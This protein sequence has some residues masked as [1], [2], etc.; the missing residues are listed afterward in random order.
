VTALFGFT[1]ADGFGAFQRASASA[2]GD[3]CAAGLLI[4]LGNGTCD[5]HPTKRGRDL[6]SQAVLEALERHEDRE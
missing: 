5:V 1:L 4:P 6:L 2:G 3:T